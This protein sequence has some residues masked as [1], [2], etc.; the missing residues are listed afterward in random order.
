LA[1]ELFASL[2]REKV[3]L[4]DRYL[5]T[6]IQLGRHDEA[7]AVARERV[8]LNPLNTQYRITLVS[9][10]LDAG[11]RG[12][13]IGAIEEIIKI[14]PSFKEQGEYFI[15]EIRAGRNP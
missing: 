13:A 5:S 7:V 8:S 3:V 12:E 14:D 9:V 11:R 6:L 15:S 2:P 1:Q 4:E 10:Y